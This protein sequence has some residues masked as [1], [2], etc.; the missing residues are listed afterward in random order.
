LSKCFHGK[1]SAKV[2]HRENGAINYRFA[3]DI[4]GFI[5]REGITNSIIRPPQNIGGKIGITVAL[6]NK[7]PT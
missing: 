4:S 3:I 1:L 2:L 6:E 5:A 7:K